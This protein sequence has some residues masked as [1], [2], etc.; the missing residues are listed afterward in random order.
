MGK[1]INTAQKPEISGKNRKNELT[2]KQVKAAACLGVGMNGREAAET[3]GV[4]ARTIRNWMKL[5]SFRTEV[6]LYSRDNL[7]QTVLQSARAI[8]LVTSR[9][10]KIIQDDDCPSQYH[11]QSSKLLLD[12]W[13]KL[14]NAKPAVREVIK[15][16]PTEIEKLTPYERGLRDGKKRKEEDM[17]EIGY[18]EGRDNPMHWMG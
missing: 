11:I 16:P 15:I 9:L 5:K 8:D 18:E 1:K 14:Q 12:L 4:R 7:D 2:P 17:Y 10:S 6:N 13:G 3:V